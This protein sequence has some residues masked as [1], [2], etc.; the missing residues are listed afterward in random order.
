MALINI[1]ISCC[2]LSVQHGRRGPGA[3]QALK[4][5]C[6]HRA[7]DDS[8]TGSGADWW[9]LSARGSV[10]ERW[11]SLSPALGQKLPQAHA[12]DQR[13][14]HCQAKSQASGTFVSMGSLQSLGRPRRSIVSVIWR[15]QNGISFRLPPKNAFFLSVVK[16]AEFVF[17]FSFSVAWCVQACVRGNLLERE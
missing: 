1:K 4:G 10:P 13:E 5:S 2:L 12:H 14:S 17:Q 6:G 15:H 3:H 16:G 11:P 9:V 8:N 7:V